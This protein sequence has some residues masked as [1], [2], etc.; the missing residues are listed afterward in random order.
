MLCL[1]SDMPGTI[2]EGEEQVKGDYSFSLG[3]RDRFGNLPRPSAEADLRWQQNPGAL[4]AGTRQASDYGSA[5]RHALHIGDDYLQLHAG[6][7]YQPWRLGQ[8]QQ[9]APIIADHHVPSAVGPH[10]SS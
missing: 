4:V 1:P 9:Q 10:K 7:E 8:Q 5:G 2:E 6:S 3:L